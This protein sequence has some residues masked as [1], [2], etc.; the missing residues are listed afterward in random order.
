MGRLTGK[1]AI[2]TGAAQG[3]GAAHARAFVKEGA[4]TV[5]TDVNAAAGA[6]LA[7]QL[8]PNAMFIQHDV[9]QQNQWSAVV[10]RA[11]SKFGKVNVLI[12]NAGVIG[13][14]AE[15]TELSEASF[16]DVC[17]VNEL[18]VFL[19]M[20]AVVPSMMACGG[21]SIVNVSSIAGMVGLDASPN[22]AYVASKFAVRG[23][24][25]FAAV[26]YGSS[27]IR[28][29]SVH[30]GYIKTP[31]MVAATDENGGGATVDIPLRRFADPAEVANL[32]VF[33]ASDESSFISGTEHVI[34]GGMLAG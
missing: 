20:R 9:R 3:M 22:F 34:D 10:E 16:L 23:M 31:M 11:E 4:K 18:G 6:E 19:G 7:G 29:N 1:V 2:I 33:L 12:N 26:R 30:P 13:P 21:G 5:L 17:A 32:M 27:N 14:V 28:V 15:L 24:T 25:K 8:G